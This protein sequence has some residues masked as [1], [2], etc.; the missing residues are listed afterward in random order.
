MWKLAEY[1]GLLYIRELPKVN[2]E[3]ER[4]SETQFLARHGLEEV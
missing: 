2:I 3:I 4:P 1:E